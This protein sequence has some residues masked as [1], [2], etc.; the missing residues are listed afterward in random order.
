MELAVLLNWTPNVED[1][2]T[3]EPPEKYVAGANDNV[4]VE[5]VASSEYKASLLAP[6]YGCVVSELFDHKVFVESG[7]EACVGS[8]T[9]FAVRTPVIPNVP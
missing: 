7:L 6:K 8:V 3:P 4:G 9:A 5:V 2:V 1:D